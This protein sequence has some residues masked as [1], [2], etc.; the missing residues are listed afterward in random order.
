[1]GGRRPASQPDG[2]GGVIAGTETAAGRIRVPARSYRYWRTRCCDDFTF[3]QF[4]E[5]FTVEGLGRRG[6]HRRPISHRLGTLRGHPTGVV[7]SGRDRMDEPRMARSS[8][9]TAVL[10]STSVCRGGSSGRRR[11]GEVAR[12]PSNDRRR[13]QRAPL[14]RHHQDVGR[15]DVRFESALSPGWQRSLQALLDRS[16]GSRRRNAGL[17]R[18][19]HRRRGAASAR[20]G[21]RRSIGKQRCRVLELERVTVSPARPTG[22]IHHAKRGPSSPPLVPAVRSRITGTAT[23]SASRSDPRGRPTYIRTDVGVGDEIEVSPP[24]CS[25]SMTVTGQSCSPTGV[26][27]PMLAMLRAR[28]PFD[29]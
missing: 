24:G 10:A 6:L 12:A 11:S 21:C 9:R 4:G 16:S 3:G 18:S 23:G 14:P 29:P 27:G 19:V 26:G 15:S 20:C 17:T 13:C 1:M 5:N 7:L 22:A 2:D 28:P 25:S 8:S